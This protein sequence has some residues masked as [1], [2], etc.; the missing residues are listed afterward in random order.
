MQQIKCKRG[1]LGEGRGVRTW[2]RDR[3]TQ[4]DLQTGTQTEE[5]ESHEER[6]DRECACAENRDREQK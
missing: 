4:D 2:G 3:S 5:K 6:D 1:C